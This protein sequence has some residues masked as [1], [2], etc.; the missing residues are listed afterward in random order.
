MNSTNS[1]AKTGD[2]DMDTTSSASASSRSEGEPEKDSTYGSCDSDDAEQRHSKLRDYQRR[3][4]SG[5][6]EKFKR[7]LLV[8]NEETE[9][10]GQLVVFTKL[11]EVLSFCTENSLSSMTADSIISLSCFLLRHDAVP[12]LCQRLMAIKYL[13]VAE[14]CLQALEKISWEQPLACLQNYKQS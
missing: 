2:H 1:S 7:I 13:D 12:A 5:D 9:E 11:C 10:S 14:Q 4:T 8:L 6:R 3:R